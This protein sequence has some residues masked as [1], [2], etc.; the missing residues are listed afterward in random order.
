MQQFSK[1]P[2][3]KPLKGTAIIAFTAEQVKTYNIHLFGDKPFE[4]ND[5]FHPEQHSIEEGMIYAVNDFQHE[6]KPGD[7]VLIDYTIFSTGRYDGPERLRSESPRLIYNDDEYYLYWCYDDTHKLN[8]SEIFAYISD[9]GAISAFGDAVIVDQIDETEG[10]IDIVLNVAD[11]NLQLPTSRWAKV[12]AS[13]VEEINAGDIIL[14]EKGLCV[15]VKFR[16]IE[17]HYINLPYILGKA[18]IS[19]PLGIE[20]F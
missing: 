11:I 2:K 1:L 17:K 8:A 6:L 10:L 12:L 5:F 13:P 9:E 15:G 3:I 4:I 7:N 19:H 16:G 20:L 14:C 18:S